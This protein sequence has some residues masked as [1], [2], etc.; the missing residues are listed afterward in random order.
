MPKVSIILPAY[1]A[2][3]T[4]A[5]AIE[6][7]LN[8]T[9]RDWELIVI[10]DGSK[11]NTEQVIRSFT[12]A[13]IRYIAN[14]GNKGLIYTLNRGISLAIGEYIARMDADDIAFPTRL[15]K[16]VN[17]LDS[18][19]E[20]IVLGTGFETFGEGVEK[21]I[22][23]LAET[24]EQIKDAYLT[25]FP[26]AH[27][28]VMMRRVE[29]LQYNSDYK[30]A[31]DYRLWL[32]L[33]NK[34]RYHNLQEVLLHYRISPSQ[35]TQRASASQQEATQRCRWEY[36][37]QRI[38]SQLSQEMKEKGIRIQHI[39]Q[40]KQQTCS[41][42]L[43]RALYLS[44]HSYGLRETTYYIFSGDIFRLGIHTAAQFTKRLLGRRAPY[45]Y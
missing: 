8:Q 20:V 16:Q 5:E 10:N 45:L 9:Y 4:V 37:S 38:G 15:E 12:D 25:E 1:N 28:T 13:R 36:L 3:L 11:D 7:M 44:L 41:L 21:R 26:F 19:P 27:P 29:G 17:Y 42:Q 22:V 31:E 18:H 40:L 43:L 6:S 14:E 33:M 23:M 30:N 39:E 34:G 24:D 2:E 35:I 32:D